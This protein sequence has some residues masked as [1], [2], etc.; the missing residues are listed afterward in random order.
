MLQGTKRG[1]GRAQTQ[2]SLVTSWHGFRGGEGL[3]LL[4]LP[5]FNTTRVLSVTRA[6]NFCSSSRTSSPADAKRHGHHHTRSRPV[7]RL[8]PSS[9]LPHAGRWVWEGPQVKMTDTGDVDFLAL[10]IPP[11]TFHCGTMTF[12]RRSKS[13]L[14]ELQQSGPKRALLS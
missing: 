6:G 3:P 2:T 4:A 12:Y 9:P 1:V 5:P 10:L 11:S 13:H 14:Q 7:K 8:R